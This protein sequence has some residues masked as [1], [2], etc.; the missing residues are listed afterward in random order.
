MDGKSA[1]SPF[2]DKVWYSKK[3]RTVY[4]VV[5]TN[6]LYGTIAESERNIETVKHQQQ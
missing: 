6:G 4:I 3:R 1:E 2:A 5:G